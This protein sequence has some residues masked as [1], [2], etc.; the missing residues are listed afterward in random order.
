MS[1]CACRQTSNDQPAIKSS[2]KTVSI[3][4]QC[5]CVCSGL[6]SSLM[7][8]SSPLET[9]SEGWASWTVSTP[10]LS[11]AADLADREACRERSSSSF[12][13]SPRTQS[14]YSMK[15]SWAIYHC[16]DTW[17][18]KTWLG[19]GFLANGGLRGGMGLLDRGCHLPA[20]CQT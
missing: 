5:V 16:K 19:C 6:Y 17:P 15:M 11:C 4:N 14:R 7:S 20:P 12:E 10:T 1:F 9:Y 18:W 2:S 13:N 3:Y 8:A